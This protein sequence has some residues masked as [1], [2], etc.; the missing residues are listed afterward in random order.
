MN[1]YRDYVDVL[2]RAFYAAR[3][4]RPG[5]VRVADLPP[6]AVDAGT[7]LLFSPHPDDESITGGLALRL[8]REA[9]MRVVNV[10]VTLGSRVSRQDERL[11]ELQDALAYLGFDLLFDKRLLTGSDKQL[12]SWIA[13]AIIEKAPRVVFLPHG[14]DWHPTHVRTHKLVMEALHSE[15]RHL[16][17]LIVETEYWQAMNAPLP[18]LLVESSANDVAALV[19]AIAFHRG[20]VSRNAYHLRFPAWMMDNVRRAEMLLGPGSGISDFVFATLYRL[21]RWEDG[22]LHKP[23]FGGSY[24]LGVGEDVS[25]L[26]F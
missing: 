20:E 16:T 8:R 12:A 1:G 23:A 18:N 15:G 2:E 25:A 5:N 22:K 4:I 14:R 3:E 24:L 11:R 17:C 6:L 21:R 13:Q 19:T 26:H 9:C 10:P 7:A